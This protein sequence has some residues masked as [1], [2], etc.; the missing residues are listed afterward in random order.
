MTESE[1]KVT[2]VDGDYVWLSQMGKPEC[3]HCQQ[4][5]GC[6]QEFKPQRVRNTVGAKAGDT[7]CVSV[8]DGAVLK[9]ALFTY[10]IPLVL[11]LLGAGVGASVGGDKGALVGCGIGLILGWWSIRGKGAH[12]QQSREPLLTMRIKVDTIHPLQR[13]SS[14]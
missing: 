11:L 2:R 7:V 5:G 4:A 14:L 10:L 1:A 9:A 13:N 12:L 3:E 8:P 6:S